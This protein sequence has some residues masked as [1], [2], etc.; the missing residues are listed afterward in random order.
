MVALEDVTIIL[1]RLLRHLDPDPVCLQDAER[2]GPHS[3]PR[4]DI[5]TAVPVQ[6]VVGL[7]QVKEDGM[8]DRLPHGDEL[9]KQLFLEGGGPRSYPCVKT[10]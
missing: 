7:A 10:M 8:D 3:I 9:L 5:T 6:V 1:P 4:Q 2:P